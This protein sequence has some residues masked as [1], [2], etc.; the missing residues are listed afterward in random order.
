MNVQHSINYFTPERLP[1]KPYCSK[2]KG[3]PTY[4]RTLKSALSYPQIQLNSPTYT[5]WLIFDVD[6]EQA[7]FAWQDCGFPPPTWVTINPEN[8]HAHIV[9]GLK[10]AVC[11]SVNARIA[12]MRY[13]AAVYKAMA[14]KMD[15]DKDYAGVLTHNPLHP[16]WRT[17]VV[18]QSNTL[19]ELGE[20]ADY[21]DLP[22]YSDHFKA[23][24][25]SEQENYAIGRNVSLF[26]RV[27]FWA[28]KAI[29]HYRSGCRSIWEQAVLSQT[30]NLNTFSVPLSYGEVK[31][32]A[33]SIS[34]WV[35]LH[36]PE[37][38]ARFCELQRERGKKAQNQVEANKASI[39][40][41]QATNEPLVALAMSLHLKGIGCSEI[42]QCVGKSVRTIWRWLA[43][44]ANMTCKNGFLI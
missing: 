22:P 40:A 32:I 4:I 36:E 17:W 31:C 7:A 8:G 10:V 21:V 41:R 2:G 27:R 9:Y 13:L 5:H 18:C 44:W 42:A 19:Y 24:Q 15:A 30:E 12:P 26:D 43:Q 39:M 25:E 11:T 38:R 35:W 28:Y 1:K 33:K 3:F 6:K 34:K 29:R 23:K 37:S 14:E 16:Q 20:L